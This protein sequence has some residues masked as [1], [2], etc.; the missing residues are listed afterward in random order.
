MLQFIYMNPVI[1]LIEDDKAISEFLT[2]V[3]TD[4]GYQVHAEYSGAAGLQLIEQVEPDA[5]L[6]D[7]FLPDIK[8]E[9][10]CRQIK[11]TY[12]EMKVIMI[13]AKD[14]P[15]QI[16]KGLDLGA[17]DYLPKPVAPEELIARLKA[18][19]RS[20]P[21]NEEILKIGHL[22]LNTKNHEVLSNGESIE[23]SPQEYKLLEYLMTQPNKVLT[24]DMILSRIWDSSPDIETRV[25]DV[26]VG[27]LRKK[28]DRPHNTNLI[29]SIRGF[30]YMIKAPDASSSTKN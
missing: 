22:S 16:A 21:L 2:D 4:N 14:T 6:L 23:L 10:I 13:T 18:R 5:V 8:G 7:L 20:T 17:D 19:L 30:G 15:E 11:D 28:I 29:Q 24:R 27:Y 12:P 26:Y 9:T 25:V 1:V 3:L